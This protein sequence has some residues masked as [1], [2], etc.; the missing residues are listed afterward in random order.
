MDSGLVH[1]SV[2]LLLEN[3]PPGLRVVVSGRADPP[4]PLPRLRARGQLA[5]LCAADLRFTGEEAAALLGE[6]ARS[7]VPG[8]SPRGWRQRGRRSRTGRNETSRFARLTWSR[9]GDQG[10]L[11]ESVMIRQLSKYGVPILPIVPV[12]STRFRGSEPFF[13]GKASPLDPDSSAN[14]TK[15]GRGRASPEGACQAV[16]RCAAAA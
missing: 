2:V 8:A 16:C 14:G 15:R 9:L 12:T 10:D 6:A 7:G 5:E 3:L 11:F 4:L 1:E 13:L